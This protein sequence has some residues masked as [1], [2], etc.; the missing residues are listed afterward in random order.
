MLISWRLL[1][2]QKQLDR[3]MFWVTMNHRQS[4]RIG[5]NC[6]CHCHCLAVIVIVLVRQDSYMLTLTL[7]SWPNQLGSVIAV[8]ASDVRVD[9]V[10]LSTRPDGLTLLSLSLTRCSTNRR[11]HLYQCVKCHSITQNS[12]W[13]ADKI[14][15]VRKTAPEL[16]SIPVKDE[17]VRKRWSVLKPPMLPFCHLS[18]L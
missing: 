17:L 8:R 18:P 10:S 13:T 7:C 6:C 16:R 15:S 3:Q 9:I 5:W 4:N 11:W 12:V 14:L 1:R 2:L